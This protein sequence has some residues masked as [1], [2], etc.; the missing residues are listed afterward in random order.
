MGRFVWSKVVKGRYAKDIHKLFVAADGG[1]IAGG[2]DNGTLFIS[3]FDSLGNP[4]WS[5]RYEDTTIEGEHV[6]QIVEAP[7]GFML[8]GGYTDP[9]TRQ[10]HL[11]MVS[12]DTE[13]HVRWARSYVVLAGELL[14]ALQGTPDGG[15]LMAGSTTITDARSRQPY[16]FKVDGN[17]KVEWAQTLQEQSPPPGLH[18]SWLAGALV[19]HDREGYMLLEQPDWQLSTFDIVSINGSGQGGCIPSILSVTA[20]D[21]ALVPTPQEDITVV[22]FPTR[23]L[24]DDAGLSSF[25]ATSNML[26]QGV[27][28]VEIETPVAAPSLALLLPNPTGRGGVARMILPPSFSGRVAVVIA[29]MGGR[30]VTRT[31]VEAGESAH[32]EGVPIETGGLPAGVYIVTASHNGKSSAARLVVR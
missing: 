22:D 30:E 6:T 20:R 11:L 14:G 26:C 25:N 27:S 18:G 24:G 13:G 7:G 23:V 4:V 15:W 3:R 10:S 21:I 28:G 17:G 9:A 1:I 5:H 19:R 8:A 2:A 16:A 32:G 12:I 29:D 31:T